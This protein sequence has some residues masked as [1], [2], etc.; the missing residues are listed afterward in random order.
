M[1]FRLELVAVIGSEVLNAERKGFNDMIHEIGGVGL[2]VAFVDF[3]GAV[4]SSMAV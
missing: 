4:A 3:Q 2:V 1:E